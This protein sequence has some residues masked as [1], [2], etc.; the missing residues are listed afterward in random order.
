MITIDEES[1]TNLYNSELN[2]SNF[3]TIP[4]TQAIVKREWKENTYSKPI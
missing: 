4:S 2:E 3:M 1:K